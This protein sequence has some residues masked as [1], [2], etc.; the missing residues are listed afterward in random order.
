MPSCICPSE[1]VQLLA[2]H[3]HPIGRFPDGLTRQNLPEWNQRPISLGAPSRHGSIPYDDTEAVMP[4]RFL[5]ELSQRWW[6]VALRGLFAIVFGVLAMLLPGV[7]LVALIFLF[8]IYSIVDG[9]LA[10]VTAFSA[11]DQGRPAWPFVIIGVAGLLAGIA[12]FF[13]P[14]ITALVLLMFIA[15]WALTIGIF[16]IVAAI[17]LRKEID[18]EWLLGLSG[19]IS[20]IFGILMIARPGAGALA[21]IV[22]ISIYSIFFGVL[23]VAL[24]LRLRKHAG[25]SAVV[26]H[27]T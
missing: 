22:I 4:T 8:G 24:G 27:S 2:P 11:R 25:L 9:G 26:R 20:V 1:V 12:A 21:V 15:F 17:R 3:E 18:N 14:G 10:L 6:L 16:Q 19:L 7:T 13:W 5:S 23:L